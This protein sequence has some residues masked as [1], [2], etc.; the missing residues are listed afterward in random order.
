MKDIWT[1]I[2]ALNKRFN[3][4]GIGNQIDFKK[5]YLYSL[6]THSTAIEG[7]TLTERDTW[8]LLDE[9]IATGERPL[10]HYKMNEDLKKAYDFVEVEAK[11]KAPITPAFLQQMNALAM[12]STGSV[13]ST[14]SGAFDSSKGEWRRIGVTA[15]YGGPSYMSSLKI[16]PAIEELCKNV[17]EKQG[18]V[19]E[20]KEKYELSF[21]AHFNLVTIH[22]WADGNGRTSRLLMNYLQIYYHLFPTKIFK[23]DRAEY[24]DVLIQSRE[25]ETTVPFIDFMAGQLKKSIETEI[26]GYESS[27]KKDFHLMF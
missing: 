19:T 18:V 6:I 4:L 2:A 13:Y 11:K 27:R 16:V 17:T 20:K 23:E 3:D 7:S 21:N 26:A 8:M 10:L 24:I 22:P 5:Y 15:G 12:N 1:E 9:G 25:Q 14:P